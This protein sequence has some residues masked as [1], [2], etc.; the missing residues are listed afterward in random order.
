MPLLELLARAIN[1]HPLI[2]M[3]FAALFIV[4]G[5]ALIFVP[6]FAW[7]I[8]FHVARQNKLLQRMIDEI[9]RLGS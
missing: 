7:G 4:W 9:R 1:S 5:L 3:A 2:Q 8:Y 6:F